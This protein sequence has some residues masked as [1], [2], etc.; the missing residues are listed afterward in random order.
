M[1][2]LLGCS[3][4]EPFFDA[5]GSSSPSVGLRAGHWLASSGVQPGASVSLET[6]EHFGAT[7]SPALSGRIPWRLAPEVSAGPVLSDSAALG[8][9]ARIG[10]S[11]EVAS[12]WGHPMALFVAARALWIDEGGRRPATTGLSLSSLK[13]GGRQPPPFVLPEPSG[14]PQ[15]GPDHPPPPVT[16][17][18]PQAP[19]GPE[20]R[21]YGD[22]VDISLLF[23]VRVSW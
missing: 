14:E 2:G 6:H 13:G 21:P 8:A 9:E 16:P 1:L 12:A 4:S 7:I 23:G 19:T 3:G 10:A 22:Q 11:Y 15:D 17:N 5:Y 18:P 20:T